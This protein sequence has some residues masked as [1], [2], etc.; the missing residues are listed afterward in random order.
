MPKSFRRTLGRHCSCA[1]SKSS[2][3]Q[4]RF[5][6]SV[7]TGRPCTLALCARPLPPSQSTARTLGRTQASVA[8][9]I[10][11]AGSLCGG[12]A[13]RG[14]QTEPAPAR[15]A[16]LHRPLLPSPPRGLMHASAPPQHRRRGPASTGCALCRRR[17]RAA[18]FRRIHL[19]LLIQARLASKRNQWNS[20][21]TPNSLNLPDQALRRRNHRRRTPFMDTAS[22][23]L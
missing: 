20:T 15:N 4:C 10:F 12:R 3:F 5:R 8:V 1:L 14:G 18:P 7:G 6:Q 16:V 22:D 11:N 2:E 19:G 23:R 9:S 13:T 17:A 21:L